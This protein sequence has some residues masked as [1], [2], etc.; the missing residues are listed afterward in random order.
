MDAPQEI[1]KTGRP[2][3]SKARTEFARKAEEEGALV[4]RVGGQLATAVRHAPD[5]LHVFYIDAEGVLRCCARADA[6]WSD[7]TLPQADGLPFGT[8]MH[9]AGALTT[10]YQAKGEQLDVFTVDRDGMLRI[11]LTP[12]GRAWEA[13]VVPE[14]IG[15]PPGASLATGYQSGGAVVDI[16]VAGRAGEALVFQGTDNGQ[17]HRARIA[18]DPPLPHGANLA[19]GYQNGGSQLAVFGI[20]RDGGL[21]AMIETGD[22]Y[23]QVESLTSQL[24]Q[25]VT[26]PPGAPLATGYPGGYRTRP[27]TGAAPAPGSNS[28]AGG[29]TVFTVDVNGRLCAFQ[30]ERFGWDVQILPGAGLHSPGALATGYQNGGRQLL[31][32]VVDEDGRLR[33]Y[34]QELDGTWS[35]GVVPNGVGLPPGAAIA[36]GY[37]SRVNMLDVF[38]LAEFAAPPIYYTAQDGGWTGP[39]RI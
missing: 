23:W 24:S 8:D 36:T 39:Y 34:A 33:Q 26:L 17:W 6:G 19:T 25:R 28:G 38:V 31:V 13:D 30:R 14:A 9:P 18:L 5:R 2:E 3:C 27:R 37:R 32:F 10:A 20:D 22:G 7:V 35:V 16:F 12:G 21:Q 4:S 1:R 29:P 11:Y 15:I